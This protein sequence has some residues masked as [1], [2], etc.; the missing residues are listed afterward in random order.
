MIQDHITSQMICKYGDAFFARKGREQSQHGY[1]AQKM[2]ELGRLVLLPK[3]LT[4]VSKVLKM[5]D[6]TKFELVIKAT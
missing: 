4:A 3:K 1:I 2:R 6:P 5:C